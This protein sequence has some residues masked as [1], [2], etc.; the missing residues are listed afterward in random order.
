MN[1]GLDRR[2]LMNKSTLLFNMI[3]LVSSMTMMIKADM[4]ELEVVCHVMTES[5]SHGVVFL[6]ADSIS[7]AETSAIGSTA[8]ISENKKEKA[9]TV[10]QCIVNDDTVL[11]DPIAEKIRSSIGR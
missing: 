4:P 8:Y 10:L 11:N 9:T 2:I 1:V 6:Q 7:L 3:L 5:N